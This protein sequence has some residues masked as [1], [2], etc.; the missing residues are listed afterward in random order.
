MSS[1][2]GVHIHKSTAILADLEDSGIAR[3]MVDGGHWHDHA[4]YNPLNTTV[5]KPGYTAFGSLGI[6]AYVSCDQGFTAA[7]ATLYSG[8]YQS[9]IAAPKAGNNAQAV[10]EADGALQGPVGAL[11]ELDLVPSL[12]RT[13]LGHRSRFSLESPPRFHSPSI[14]IV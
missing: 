12:I 13:R 2:R 9:M 7:I 6:G 5:P 1:R 4:R 8:D 14:G 11:I 10:A 3:E